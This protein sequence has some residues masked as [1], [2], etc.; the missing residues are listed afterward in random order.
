[1]CVLNVPNDP[2]LA[3]SYSLQFNHTYRPIFICLIFCL[4]PFPAVALGPTSVRTTSFVTVYG[5]RAVGLCV[6][7]WRVCARAPIGQA[8]A[9]ETNGSSKQMA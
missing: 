9:I 1:M 7:Q 3:F 4:G 8:L 5:S 2:K 6:V